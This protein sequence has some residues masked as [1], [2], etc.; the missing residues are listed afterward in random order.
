MGH[1][2]A[3]RVDPAFHGRLGLVAKRVIILLEGPDGAGK[4]TLAQ[5]LG[6]HY[7]HATY[8]FKGRMPAYHTALFK[9][10]VELSEADHV[11]LDRWRFSEE[12]YGMVFRGE[13]EE[14]ELDWFF[15]DLLTKNAV[16][17]ILCIPEDRERYLDEFRKLTNERDE[18][19]T[20]VDKMGEIY[21]YYYARKGMFPL[22]YDRFTANSKWPMQTLATAITQFN[23]VR[24]T[25]IT[26]ARKGAATMPEIAFK[27]TD[28]FQPPAKGYR[29][30]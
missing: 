25:P 7:L 28:A 16:F 12:V 14:P 13:Y 21:D 17:K 22:H 26:C 5:K 1:S 23:Y 9:K 29:D 15:N 27:H 20:D 8:R 10:A 4:T 2:E 19:Y 24:K 6:G 3:D 30:E 11:V 18:M